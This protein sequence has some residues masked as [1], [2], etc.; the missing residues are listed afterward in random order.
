MS[1]SEKLRAL[2]EQLAPFSYVGAG[3]SGQAKSDVL[4]ALP[5]LM[6]LVEIAERM[7]VPNPHM[8]HALQWK[9]HTAIA[10]LDG[11]LQ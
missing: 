8:P 4:N 2:G 5:Q 9:L 11:A 1:A 6:A 7:D 3:P 10:A